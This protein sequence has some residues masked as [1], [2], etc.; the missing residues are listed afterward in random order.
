MQLSASQIQA[1]AAVMQS[2]IQG[3]TVQ[4]APAK[5]VH[6]VATLAV[7]VKD[8]V[9]TLTFPFPTTWNESST[10]KSDTAFVN[11][12]PISYN[13]KLVR[14]GLNLFSKATK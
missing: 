2:Q 1:I 6:P 5:K 11:I 9:A 13:G 10:G 4:S 14:G 8:G 3:A 12:P 7:N